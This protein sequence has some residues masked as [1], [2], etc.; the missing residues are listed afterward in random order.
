M[1]A[2]TCSRWAGFWPRRW[3]QDG[4]ALA[5][6]R[7][8]D[9]V[10]DRGSHVRPCGPRHLLP[11]LSTGARTF[12]LGGFSTEARDPAT[13]FDRHTGKSASHFRHVA[14]LLHNRTG[15]M[16]NAKPDQPCTD[17]RNR[18]ARRGFDQCKEHY[19]SSIRP[20]VLYFGTSTLRICA[21]HSLDC[22]V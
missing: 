9:Y 2:K 22:A 8:A 14:P 4:R 20:A 3:R 17:Q 18:L 12:R 13:R 6:T 11:L 10:A 19:N 5:A 15:C 1:Q 16:Q 7:L 21:N